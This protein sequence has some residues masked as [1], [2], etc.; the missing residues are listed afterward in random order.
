[1]DIAKDVSKRATCE[2]AH[3]GCILV[4][5]KRIIATGYNGSVSGMPHCDEAGHDLVD[6]HCVRTI[7]AEANA[8]LQCAVYG[9]PLIHK[10]ITAY[11]NYMPCLKCIQ[12]LVN[13][14]IRKIIFEDF[15]GKWNKEDI[16]RLMN[17]KKFCDLSICRFERKSEGVFTLCGKMDEICTMLSEF[18][19]S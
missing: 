8:V 9:V 7:H 15:Y 13:V 6:G 10:D 1:M 19:N 18:S 2:R 17:Y 12:L 16:E 3:V 11:C 4:D 5:D 14:G